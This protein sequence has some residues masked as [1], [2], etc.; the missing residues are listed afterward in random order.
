MAQRSL[1]RAALGQAF[2]QLAPVLRRHYDLE[3]GQE[4]IVRGPMDAWNR[5]AFARALIPFMPVPGKAVP[6]VVRNR[7]LLDGGEVCYEW[8]REF[9]NPGGKAVSYTLTR[10]TPALTT[11]P[12][13][14]DTFN[15]P[16]NI[17]VTLALEV[18]EEGRALKQTTVGPQ[19]A[20]RNSKLTTLPGL[21]SIRST[22]IERAVDERT[23]QTDVIV[24][25]PLFGRMFGYSGRLTV[26]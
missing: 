24:S 9:N 13:V 26:G 2:D 3:P 25:H 12:S 1:F 21:F 7:G 11:E 18:M 6:V 17:G 19:Y 4:I 15:Q 23:I 8:V 14:L 5:F 22:A 10:P 16:P 20:I